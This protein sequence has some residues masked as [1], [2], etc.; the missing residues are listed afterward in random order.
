MK[1][2][3]IAN[4]CWNILNFRKKL[5]TD[6]YLK[7][8]KIILSAPIDKSL[9]KIDKSKFSYLPINYNR[10]SFNLLK[11]LYIILFYVR[12]FNLHKPQKILLYTIKPNIFCS[13][14]T[15]FTYKNIEI[16]N[17]ITGLGSLFFSNPFK[18]KII[19]FLYKIA[20]LKSN[21]VIFQNTN[22]LNYFVSNKI[23]SKKK[24]LIIP[25]S[26]VDINFFKFKKL[27]IKNKFNLN[28]LCISRLIKHKGID[29][30]IYKEVEY[31]TYGKVCDSYAWGGGNLPI[32]LYNHAKDKL[33]EHESTLS[34]PVISTD[35]NTSDTLIQKYQ[36]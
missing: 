17:F 18:K 7:K 34:G 16:Y 19:I 14:S 28:F 30:F 13:L 23:I 35:Q 32:T 4:S 12:Q 25:G 36:T 29:E 20:F 3:I 1:I 8:N 5:I 22:D 10:K 11:N 27:N 15:F 33:W 21:K 6:L 26:G 24:C 2:F 31:E 9:E